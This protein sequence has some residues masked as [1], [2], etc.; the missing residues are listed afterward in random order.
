MAL[1]LCVICLHII[2]KEIRKT[3]VWN[4]LAYWSLVNVGE[5]REV[6]ENSTLILAAGLED[7]IIL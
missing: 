3:Q 6:V 7:V 5:R 2:R 1:L 4:I